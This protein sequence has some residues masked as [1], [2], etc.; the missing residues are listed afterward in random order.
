MNSNETTADV[1]DHDFNSSSARSYRKWRHIKDVATRY[2]M[3]FGGVSVIAAI[4][5]I[6]FYLLY[7]V[8]PMFKSAEIEQI[9]TYSVPGGSESETLY[10]AMEEQR[11]IGL[12]INNLGQV[13]FFNTANGEI[14]S[15]VDL[16]LSDDVSIYSGIQWRSN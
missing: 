8:V 6:A 5:L 9:A 7:V 11:E 12:R 14:R 3:A 15:S 1:L 16:R 13:V 4:V 10:V 2:L